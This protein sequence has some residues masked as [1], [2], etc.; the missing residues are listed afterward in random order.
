MDHDLT[1]E[2]T[3]EGAEALIASGLL[4]G[5]VREDVR[6]EVHFDT[7]GG[8]LAA[9]GLRLFIGGAEG[10][11]VQTLAGAG[12]ARDTLVEGD[13]PVS[14]LP[15]VPVFTVTLLRRE[16]LVDSGGATL[17]VQLDQGEI[18][19]ADRRAPICE[20]ALHLRSGPAEALHAFARTLDGVAPLRLRVLT[21]AERGQRLIGALPDRVKADPVALSR[22][23]SAEDAFRE[24]VRT[25]IRHIRQNETLLACSRSAEALHQTRVGLRRLRSALTIAKPLLGADGADLKADLRA[26]ATELGTAR[27]LDVL[28]ERAPP[29]EARDRIRDERE[30]AHDR[31]AQMLASDRARDVMLDLVAWLDC[32][33]WR[34]DPATEGARSAPARDFAAGALRRFRRKIKADGRH[35]A[36]LPDAQ[37]HEVRKDAKKL[38]YAAD[39]FIPLFGRPKRQRRF[40]SALEAL[41]EHLGALN[42]L[43]T[44]PTLLARLGLPVPPTE[45]RRA[46]LL[47]AAEEAWETLVAARSYWR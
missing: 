32:G 35:L 10:R 43:A 16:W 39:F 45:E 34:S 41:Q 17:R 22:E 14:D 15:L 28:L 21:A 23:M 47:P 40:L 6:R 3:P 38:R 37:R 9:E 13:R 11:R 24:I 26:L 46:A 12:L 30:A 29:G 1:L 27:D 2:L 4:T 8:D 33:A 44:E 42:D 20:I 5:Q 31:V 18:V 25:C 36:R 19:A 7:A